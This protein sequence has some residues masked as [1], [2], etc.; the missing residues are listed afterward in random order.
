MNAND[1]T[2]TELATV[3][4]GSRVENNAPNAPAD[5]SFDLVIEAAAGNTV[6]NSGALHPH[7]QRDRPDRSRPALAPQVLAQAFNPAAGWELSGAGPNYE[8]TQT[9][10]IAVPGGGPGGPWPATPCNSWHPSSARAPKSS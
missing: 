9:I 4:T 2:L 5:A 1:A 8:Y 6:G 3:H 7:H 10:P